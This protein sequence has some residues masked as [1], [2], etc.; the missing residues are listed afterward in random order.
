MLIELINKY[1]KDNNI[2]DPKE[3]VICI[4]DRLT[5]YKDKADFIINNYMLDYDISAQQAAEIW[6]KDKLY[7]Y[8]TH[9][10]TYN[11]I[12]N[13]NI[14]LNVSKSHYDIAISFLDQEIFTENFEHNNKWI[15]DYNGCYISLLELDNMGLLDYLLCE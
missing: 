2:A 4:S 6:D 5:I 14:L 7:L 13:K 1:I 11:D 15:T 3:L 12:D 10:T 9:T 8:G